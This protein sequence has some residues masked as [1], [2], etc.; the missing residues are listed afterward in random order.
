MKKRVTLDDIAAACNTSPAT[1][2]LALRN[3]AGV[4]RERRAEILETAQKLGYVPKRRDGRG[5]GAPMRPVALVFRTPNWTAERTA[6]ALNHFYSWVLTGIQDGATEHRLNLN[7]GTIPV[8]INNHATTLPEMLRSRPLDGVLL[9]GAFQEETVASVRELAGG[10]NL[11]M[12]LVDNITP[13]LRVDWVTSE[14][15]QGMAE[16]TR[17]LIDAGHREIAFA[18]LPDG[19]DRNFD[20]R[21]AGYYRA[22]E[23][24]GLLTAEL[25]AG[26]AVA[27]LREDLEQRRGTFT[28]LACA[29]DHT[30]ALMVNT[31]R[32]VGIDVPNELSVVGFDDT[33]E[34]RHIHPAISTMSVD[35]PGMGRL[36][37]KMLHYRL[38]WPD[39]A[40]MHMSLGTHLIRRESVMAHQADEAIEKAPVGSV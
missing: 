20:L 7:L 39:G 29:N 3:R 34:G 35:K 12:V 32:S 25:N 9:V 37:V 15:W 40:P 28:A 6:P 16:A 4:S 10:G 1:V 26:A 11:P 5:D 13:G 23:E 30:A 17:H 27:T 36:A 21:R 19:I 8:D 31:A 14:H 22:M 18:G 24:S 33:T 38:D 2:S